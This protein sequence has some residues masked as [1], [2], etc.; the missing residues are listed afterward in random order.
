MAYDW[1]GNVRELENFVERCIALG[2]G[3]ILE[4]E[5][6]CMNLKQ[7]GER[8]IPSEVIKNEPIHVMKQRMILNVLAQTNGDKK[9]A[10]RILGIGTTTLYRKLDEY[11]RALN[12]CANAH[13]QSN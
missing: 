13:P 4:D 5:D 11:K 7:T 9:G 10:A 6:G 8:L 12:L 2:S 3:P 1:P